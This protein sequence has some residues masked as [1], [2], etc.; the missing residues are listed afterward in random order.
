MS[1]KAQAARL[2]KMRFAMA[3]AARHLPPGLP[4]LFAL[5][6]PVRTP[7]PS[8]LA[9]GLP[10]G[11][12][13]IYRHFG[14]GDRREV[15]AKLATI[16]KKRGLLFLVANDG[17]LAR[18]VG[19]DGVH[20]PEM[21][22]AEARKW[23]GAFQIMTCSAHSRAALQRAG[24][25]G[26][27]AALLSAVFPSTSQSAGPPTGALRFRTLARQAGFPVYALGGI[28]ADNAGQI[29]THAGIAAVEACWDLFV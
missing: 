26:V 13:L 28:T 1:D 7:D 5:T 4:S 16:S 25:A 18:V 3:R 19:A 29:S 27:D 22:L 12:G 2:R 15:A 8:A 21:N 10:R 9:K 24:R 17:R 20:W 11:T 23:A 14:A 6:D